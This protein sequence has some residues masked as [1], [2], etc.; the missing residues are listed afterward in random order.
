MSGRLRRAVAAT[1][2]AVAGL[3]VVAPGAT[4]ETGP[5]DESL[6]FRFPAADPMRVPGTNTYVAYG[7]S[8]PGNK[9]LYTVF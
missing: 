7:A 6:D 4:G 5:R 3:L 9:L 8:S 2:A 1:V